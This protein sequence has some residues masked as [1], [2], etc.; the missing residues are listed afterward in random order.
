MASRKSRSVAANARAVSSCPF[1][2]IR[3]RPRPRS[4]PAHSANTAPITATAAATFRPVN[5]D[6]SAAGASTSRSA[7]QRVAWS[8]RSSRRASGS[9]ARRP[10]YRLIV[11]GKKQTSATSSTLGARPK[12]NT[13][14]TS[15]AMTGTGTACEPITSGRSARRSAGERCIATPSAAPAT[16]AASRP[17]ST[18]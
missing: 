5:A 8:D 4:A 14:I 3:T 1:A 10:S 7:C 6:G 18:S 2:V 13:R 15:G 16:A 11:I 9:A 17:S 12:P